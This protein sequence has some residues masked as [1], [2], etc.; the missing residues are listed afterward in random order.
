MKTAISKME[1]VNN[2]TVGDSHTEYLHKQNRIPHNHRYVGIYED[3]MRDAIVVE[4]LP[5]FLAFFVYLKW[6]IQGRMY[7]RA[8][9]RTI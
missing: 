8:L 7:W 2:L 3:E 5:G 6:I 1:I 4:T 9:K